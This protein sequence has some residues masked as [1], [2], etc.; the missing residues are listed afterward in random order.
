MSHFQHVAPRSSTA[1]ELVF[2][3]NP[4]LCSPTKAKARGALGEDVLAS[5]LLSAVR[6][7][8]GAAVAAL[9][10]NGANVDICDQQ[11]YTPLLLAAE[12]GHTEVF[13]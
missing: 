3:Y 12:L 6:Q 10:D 8:Q 11:G 5:A 9:I 1:V 7:N 4:P 2:Y 13:R